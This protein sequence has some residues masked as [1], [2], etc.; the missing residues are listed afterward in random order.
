MSADEEVTA[1][2]AAEVIAIRLVFSVVGVGVKGQIVDVAPE[3]AAELVSAHAAVFLDPPA[4]P[5]AD[6]E[7]VE[8]APA[9]EESTEEATTGGKGARTRESRPRSSTGR[10][11]ASGGAAGAADDT[12][13]TESGEGN[14]AG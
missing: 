11:D 7:D 8:A 1:Q 13:H 9:G 14:L 4:E 5:A 3:R 10:L 12:R 2:E 6:T